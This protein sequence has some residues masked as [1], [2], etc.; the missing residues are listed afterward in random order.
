MIYESPMV[1]E[2]LKLERLPTISCS[3][4]YKLPNVK[5]MREIEIRGITL[6]FLKS[7]KAKIENKNVKTRIIKF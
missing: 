4:T 3:E 6:F 1:Y 7:V 5:K 2:L